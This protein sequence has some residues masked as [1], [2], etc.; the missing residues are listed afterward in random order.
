MTL[1]D[2]AP[3]RFVKHVVRRATLVARATASATQSA[4]HSTKSGKQIA[5]EQTSSL[6]APVVAII[7]GGLIG[8][9]ILFVLVGI[10]CKY[11]NRPRADNRPYNHVKTMYQPSAAGYGS[12]AANNGGGGTYRGNESMHDVS[13]PKAG[14]LDS[15]QPMGRGGRYEEAD[16]SPG[17]SNGNDNG[18]AARGTNGGFGMI[19]SNSASSFRGNESNRFGGPARRGHA[20]GASTGID[21]PGPAASAAFRRNVSGSHPPIHSNPDDSYDAPHTA[22]GLLSSSVMPDGSGFTPGQIFDH[23]A[24]NGGGAPKASA[25]MREHRSS[26]LGGPP[27]GVLPRRTSLVQQNPQQRPYARGPPPSSSKNRRSR[28]AQNQTSTD[29]AHARR[30]RIDSVGPGTYRKSMFLPNDDS[31]TDF[32]GGSQMRR[33]PSN[34][35]SDAPKPLRRVESIGKGDPRRTSRYAHNKEGS[36]VLLPTRAPDADDMPPA[37]AAVGYRDG[38][39]ASNGD[40]F[41]STAGGHGGHDGGYSPYGGGSNGSPSPLG[42]LGPNDPMLTMQQQQQ[43]YAPGGGVRMMPYGAGFGAP[44]PRPG[45]ATTQISS[46]SSFAPAAPLG[47]GL[48]RGMEASSHAATRQIL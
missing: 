2:D 47:A 45:I 46:P 9:F 41:L 26:Y 14:L 11:A 30:S 5:R 6:E 34:N 42:P 27:V 35:N 36:R 48:G 3:R 12:A 39:P 37:N 1:H 17:S 31:T 16:D 20:R 10:T 15:A 43:Q 28:Y 25:E 33:M 44:M 32:S 19:S 13:N 24:I 8:V 23:N 29:S 21:L 7:L 40:A 38:L 4:A 22:N 18:F